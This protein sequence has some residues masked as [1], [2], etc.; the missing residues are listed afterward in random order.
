MITGFA[1]LPSIPMASIY[2]LLL[3]TKLLGFGTW[4]SER[5]R[6]KYKT[7]MTTLF[8]RFGSTKNMQS[9]PALETIWKSKFGILNDS[10]LVIFVSRLHYLFSYTYCLHFLHYNFTCQD[11]TTTALT[12]L[13]SGQEISKNIT[14]LKKRAIESNSDTCVAQLVRARVS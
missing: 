5:K 6:K 3:T 1:P 4:T 9:S 13:F 11:K 2:T 14:V 8:P 10:F 12:T 7:P